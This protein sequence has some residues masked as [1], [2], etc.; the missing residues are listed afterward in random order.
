M[1]KRKP[2]RPAT[3][4]DPVTSLRLA[5]ELRKR[6]SRWAATQPDTPP[7]AETIRRLLEIGLKAVPVGKEKSGVA[8]CQK[9]KQAPKQLWCQ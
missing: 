7:M 8:S 9:W 4:R 2:G 1:P 3:G 6:L 5:P